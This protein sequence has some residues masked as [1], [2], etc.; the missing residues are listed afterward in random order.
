M[1]VRYAKKDQSLSVLNSSAF[2]NK[3]TPYRCTRY[4]NPVSITESFGQ[5]SKLLKKSKEPNHDHGT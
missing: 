3:T 1:H 2:L 4:V 5:L